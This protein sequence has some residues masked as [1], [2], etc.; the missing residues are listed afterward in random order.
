MGLVTITLLAGLLRNAQASHNNICYLVA[1]AGGGPPGNDLLTQ[2]DTTDFDPA[3]NETDI[4][5][6]TGTSTMETIAFQPGPGPGTI[7]PLYAADAGQLGTLSLTTGLFTP[8]SSTFG[9]G[10]GSLG[11]ITFSDVD[12]LAFDT[13]TGALYG[14][15]R[16]GGVPND[17]L[18][19]QISPLTGAHIPDAFGAGIDYVVISSFSV[20]GLADI[21][22]ISIDPSDGRMYASANNGG[23][24]ERLVRIDVSTGAVTDISDFGVDD[25]EGLSFDDSGQLWGTTGT[26]ALP[27]EQNSLYEISLITGA[28]INRRALDNGTDYESVACHKT[29]SAMATPTPT[30]TPP[31]TPTNTPPPTGILTPAP[32]A[33][34]TPQIVDPLT[35]VPELPDTGFAPGR[36]SALPAP[37]SDIRYRSLGDLWLE[38]PDLGVQIPIVGV[39]LQEEGWDVT[40]LWDQAG[41]LEGTAFPTWGGNTAISG[42]VYLSDGTAGPFVHL[43]ELLWG[44]EVIIHAFGQRYRYEV[45]EVMNVRP[46]DLSVL[47]HEEYDWVTLITCQGYDE[48][49]DA[50]RSRMVVRAVLVEVTQP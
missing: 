12:G 11:A 17:D 44:D 18:L 34:V 41:Y 28:A 24:G 14:S 26:A 29:L 43:G 39:P 38:V 20:V 45:R 40:R 47:R 2:V 22:D 23:A 30:N 8:T 15:H 33:V 50:Y 6:G 13:F 48:Q 16:R 37:F 42:H 35:D 49:Q 27:G 7:G 36:V 19:I 5:T 46:D 4:G 10:N 31:P 32:P 3:S 1:D 25:I 21:D 9:T